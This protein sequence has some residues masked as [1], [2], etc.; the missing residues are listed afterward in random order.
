LLTRGAVQSPT[1]RRLIT[2]INETD[3]IVYVENGHC[4][5]GVHNCLLFSIT[6]AG[7]FRFLRIVIDTNRFDHPERSKELVASMGHE[8]HHAVEVLTQPHVRSTI[9]M[10]SLYANDAGGG[11]G[12]FETDAAVRTGDQVLNEIAG[13]ISDSD[14]EGREPLLGAPIAASGTPSSRRC[15]TKRRLQR[16]CASSN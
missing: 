13:G 12:H 5:H 8:L 7:G 9:D 2:A 16:P 1:L 6:S 11:N 10:F 4:G 14:Y 3:G 15:T